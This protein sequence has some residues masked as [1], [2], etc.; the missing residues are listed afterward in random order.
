MS[1]YTNRKSFDEVFNKVLKEMPEEKFV[2]YPDPQFS[3]EELIQHKHMTENENAT[4]VP[5]IKIPELPSVKIP[6][7]PSVKTPELP[8]V[9]IP[10]SPSI[11]IPESPSIKTPEELKFIVNEIDKEVVTEVVTEVETDLVKQNQGETEPKELTDEEKRQKLLEALKK[12]HQRYHPKKEFGSAY[13]QKRKAKN[14][15]QKKSRKLARKK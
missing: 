7:S 3:I 5:S 4:G 9:S 1:G 14:H 2:V 10:E 8:S 12:S 11:K 13:K 6:E 15:S